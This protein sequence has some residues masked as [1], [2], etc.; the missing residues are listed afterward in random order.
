MFTIIVECACNSRGV[1]YVTNSVI[2]RSVRA[3]ETDAKVGFGNQDPCLNSLVCG[4][5]S[6]GGYQH[7]LNFIFSMSNNNRPFLGSRQN[8]RGQPIT[9]KHSIMFCIC[10]LQAQPCF[11]SQIFIYMGAFHNFIHLISL[12]RVFTLCFGLK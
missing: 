4:R 9:I 8:C 1:L 10:L 6:P 12:L 2:C 11:I 7:T 5:Q 3:C